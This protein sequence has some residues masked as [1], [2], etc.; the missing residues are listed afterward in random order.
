M[1]LLNDLRKEVESAKESGKA[2]LEGVKKSDIRDPSKWWIHDTHDRDLLV[3]IFKHG[4]G[5][6]DS[7]IYDSE[8]SFLEVIKA[9]F[10]ECFGKDAPAEPPEDEP[11]EDESTGP[12]EDVIKSRRAKRPRGVVATHGIAFHNYIGWPAGRTMEHYVQ[13]LVD[14]SKKARRKAEK[15]AKKAEKKAEKK[16]KKSKHH[17]HHKSHHSE[18]GDDGKE[19][20]EKEDSKKEEKK[21]DE[22][23]ADKVDGEEDDDEDESSSE[24]DNGDSD[25]SMDDDDAAGD[26]D[27]KGSVTEDDA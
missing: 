25:F 2:V 17:H 13:T 1:L 24:S 22:K 18:K 20:D 23:E 10:P 21:E 3:G 14:C 12:A 16:A 15:K 9:T 26:D 5:A 27:D 6:W 7:I 4:W 19:A 11:Q 8:L